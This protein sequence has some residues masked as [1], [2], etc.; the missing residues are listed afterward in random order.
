MLLEVRGL[1][2]VVFY[3]VEDIRVCEVEKPKAGRGEVIV[4]IKSAAICGTDLH[5]YRGDAIPGKLPIILG[6]EFSGVVVEVGEG[7]KDVS[8]GDRVVGPPSISCGECYYCRE[9]REQLCLNRIGLGVH[10]DGCL[11]EYVKIPRADRALCKLPDDISFEEGCLIGDVMLTGFHAAEKVTPGDIVAVFG[12]GPI[13]FSSMLFARVKGAS[14]VICVGRRDVALNFARE[15]LRVDATVNVKR[16]NVVEKIKD[17]TGGLGVDVA[18]D[19]A[20]AQFTLKSAIDCLKRGGKLVVPAL[21]AEPPTLDMIKV[22]M[23][24]LEIYGVL[25]PAN[26]NEIQRVIE[27]LRSKKIDVRSFITHRLS[28][29][30]VPRGFEILDKRIDNPVKVIIKP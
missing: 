1:R 14:K 26:V 30:E 7:V 3:G 2:A 25:C 23:N 5:Y 17:L 18:I 10:I 8:K 12:T 27:I 24:E 19:A 6:H 9:G 13:G 11:A 21:F 28:L 22:T 4:E 15:K 16:E 29:D 20:G